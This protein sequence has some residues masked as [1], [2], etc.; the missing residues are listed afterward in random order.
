[1]LQDNVKNSIT[2]TLLVI[3]CHWPEPNATAAGV[4]MLQLLKFFLKQHYQITF[5]ATMPENEHV[6]LL[7]EMGIRTTLIELNSSSFDTFIAKLE[8]QIVLFDRFVTEEQFGWRV[9]AHCPDAL[10]ILDTEDLHSLRHVREQA[11]KKGLP[12]EVNAWLQNDKTKREMASIYR[13][14][15]A[16]IISSYEMKLLQE[17]IKIDE[18]L[19]LHLPFMLAEKDIPSSLPSFSERADFVFIG[20][21]KHAPNVDAMIH[22]KQNIWPKIK[23]ALPNTRLHIY[24]AYLPQ[25]V[26]E[27]HDEKTGF[28][29]HGRA[30][31]VKAVMV[32]NRICLAPLRFGA[33]IKGKLLHA[34]QYG[35]PSVTTS[36][37]AEGMHSNMEWNGFIVDDTTDFIKAAIKLYTAVD[38]WTKAQTQGITLL[39]NCFSIANL[40]KQLQTKIQQVQKDIVEHRAQNFIGNLLQHQTMTS[41]KY[42]S[43]WIE[44]KNK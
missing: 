37:G 41:T 6:Q 25:Q 4:R 5:V 16:L 30:K 19:L 27:F 28:L 34:M 38:I 26:M 13:C 29:V 33:G 2:N 18:N 17:V 7:H 14:D 21:G 36:I 1:M 9:A 42:L 3:G 11:F 12:F 40:E 35:I 39:Q 20:G 22:L 32:A 15:I 8:P 43:K 31:T 44:E 24:G 23:A 10:R